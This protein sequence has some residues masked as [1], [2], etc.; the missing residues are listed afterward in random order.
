[1]SLI[2]QRRLSGGV[3]AEG[4]ELGGVDVVSAAAAAS[5]AARRGSMVAAT[6]DC[7]I[8]TRRDG[9][10]IVTMSQTDVLQKTNYIIVLSPT[11]VRRFDGLLLSIR[12]DQ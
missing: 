1:M 7:T 6:V 8:A 3:S 9:G 2:P 4:G 5:A 11:R 10:Y 12:T